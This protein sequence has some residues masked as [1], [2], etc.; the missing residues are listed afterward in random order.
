MDEKI[1][2]NSNKEEIIIEEDNGQTFVIEVDELIEELESIGDYDGIK[3]IEK[4]LEEM[5]N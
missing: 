2:T 3:E 1:K 4:D 5:S